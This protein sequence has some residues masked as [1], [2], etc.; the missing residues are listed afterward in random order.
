MSIIILLFLVLAVLI[1]FYKNNQTHIEQEQSIPSESA[2]AQMAH[3]T[4][5]TNDNLI[6][7]YKSLQ[8]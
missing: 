6:Y 3:Q 7:Q 1:F 8:I 2:T 4:K 5:I